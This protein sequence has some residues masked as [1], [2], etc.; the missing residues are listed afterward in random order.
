MLFYIEKGSDIIRLDAVAYI[1]K[2]LGTNCVSRKQVHIILKL[3]R[4]VLKLV[5]PNIMLLSEVNLPQKQNISYFGEGE[6]ESHIIYDFTL[7]PLLLFSFC[8]GN[9]K[10][11]S[12]WASH[13]RVKSDLDFIFN[14]LDSHDG[15]GLSPVH[16]ILTERESEFMT[17]IVRKRGGL[18]SCMIDDGRKA[19]YELNTT[20]FSALK[21]DNE[22]EDLSIRKYLCSRA[23]ALSLEGIPGIY[24]QGFFG[25][26]N[27]LGKVSKTGLK[28]DI[29]RS[30]LNIDELTKKLK[31]KN[32]RES[33]I[34]TQLIN[35]IKIRIKQKPFHPAAKQEVLFLN[36]HVF[37]I[38]RTSG[39]ENI[40]A[41]HNVSSLE[42]Q[43]DVKRFK[44]KEAV[45][46]ISKRGISDKIVLEPYQFMWVKFQ[47]TTPG[48]H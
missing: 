41:M 31:D 6:D 43:I 48:F 47:R 17:D 28:R 25:L 13:L 39:R 21:N 40:L 38:V 45:D 30:E 2:D 14:S 29:N 42:Q 16:G 5:A 44:M 26:E 35:L 36:N 9:A 37:S 24:I 1:W 33:R 4:A 19:P 11:L 34:F 12:K 8:K 22:G 18:V 3:F 7:P 32:S 23:V 10:K 20:W 27:D 46:L 15:I